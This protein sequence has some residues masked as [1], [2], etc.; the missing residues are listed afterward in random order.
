MLFRSILA[1]SGV[2]NEKLDEFDRH[3]DET[4]GESTSLLMSNIVET[5]SFE[6]K[7]PDVVIK[8]KPDRTDLIETRQI[9]GRECLVI[10]LDGGIEVNG[11]TVRTAGGMDPNETDDI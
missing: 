7:T 5:R 6:V 9:D 4:A 2:A 10:A 11:I 1:D 3:Y 8:V